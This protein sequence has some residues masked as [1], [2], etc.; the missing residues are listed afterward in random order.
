L[1]PGGVD[2]HGGDVPIVFVSDPT[3]EAERVSRALRAGGYTVVDVPLSM[4]VARVAVQ[5]PRL[6]VV[7]AD[8]HGALEAVSRMRELPQTEDVPVVFVAASR[9]AMS[10]LQEGVAQAGGA[11]FVRPVDVPALVRHVETLGSD[12]RSSPSHSSTPPPAIPTSNRSHPPAS[13]PSLAGP[14]GSTPIGVPPM[15]AFNEP[16]PGPA[17]G[18]LAGRIRVA[19]AFSPELQ[20]LLADAEERVSI[21]EEHVAAPSPEQEL[22]AV[23]PEDLLMALDDPIDEDPGPEDHPPPRSTAPRGARER[24]TDLGMSRTTSGVST[25]GGATPSA[26]GASRSVE[27]E[28]VEARE[29]AR[30]PD[31]VGPAKASYA[32]APAPARTADSRRAYVEREVSRGSGDATRLVGRAIAARTSG[33]VCLVAGAVE[34]RVVMHEGDVVTCASTA[35]DESLIAFLGARGDLPRET[36]RRLGAKFAPFGRHAGAALVARGYLLQDQMWPTLRAHAEWVFGRSL[37]W[38]ESRVRVEAQAPGRLAAEPGVFG[39]APGAEVFVEIVRRIVAPEE[40]VDRL[41]GPSCRLARGPAAELLGECALR[42]S[43]VETVRNSAGRTL[44]DVLEGALDGDFASTL[45]ALAELGIVDVLPAVGHAA[46]PASGFASAEASA[47]DADAV[48]ERVRARLQLV[49]DGDYFAV[50]GVAR[51]ATGYEVRRAFLELRRAFD[52]SRLLS[53]DVADLADDVRVIAT[54]LDEAYEILKDSARRERYRRAIEIA[55]ER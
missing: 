12:A 1:S 24:T 43:D 32:R 23:L 29:P 54:V 16:A 25:A 15:A 51:E 40:G 11:L 45:F 33:S 9:D 37:Q 44:G 19:P 2:D 27:S 53:G 52:P 5:R 28:R 3:A 48:R 36:V 34:R 30:A 18:P 20:R 31:H 35:E 55:P 46:E 21:P 42:S 49:E 39:G 13:R 22:E 14:S 7:D 8:S 41:G 4:L 47:L 38:V 10:G 26:S 6:V 17:A 50:L